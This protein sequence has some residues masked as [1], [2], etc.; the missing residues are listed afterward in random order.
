MSV[1]V[2][3]AVP[4]FM[5]MTFVGLEGLPA[6]G[7]ERFAGDL[8]RR[9]AAARSPRSA[10]PG[11]GCRTALAAPLG[12]DAAGDLIGPMLEAEGVQLVGARCPRT[13]ITAVMPV[14]PER[15]M[16]TY[17]PG[18]RAR[19]SDVASLAPRAVITGLSQLDVVPAGAR[20]Y[21]SVGD[22][23]ARAFAGRLP[24]AASRATGLF[25]EQREAL[26]LTGA[27][28]A[29]EAAEMIGARVKIV[30]V[31]LGADGAAACID[32]R[33]GDGRA[34]STSATRSTPPAPATCSSPP[35]PGATRSGWT[36]T[37]RC[38][39]P[40][41]T[42]RCR[43]ASRPGRAARPGSR[44]SSRKAR[45]AGCPARRRRAASACA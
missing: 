36:S 42:R 29:E 35:G 12:E 21:V 37:T 31:S 10:P 15:A 45:G 13:P 28:S 1:D 6:L 9:P 27:G 11:S 19:A 32:G 30:V 41:C 34:A 20:A 4:A 24:G 16:V 26:V 25:I 33:A 8:V 2:V 18:I 39:G 5:D 23:D 22:D 40:R 38:S 43:C 17:D 7:E 3:V 14:G 44:S